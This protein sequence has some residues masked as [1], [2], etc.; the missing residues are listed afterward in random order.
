AL[1][2]HHAHATFFLTGKFCREFPRQARSIA[3]AGMELG[4]HSDTH[5]RF[6]RLSA[7]QIRGQLSRAEDAIARTCG[8]GARPL[9]R[10]PYG[11]S[12]DRTRSVVAAAGYQA[13]GW[14]LDSLDSVGKPKSAAF[15]DA[16]IIHRLRPGYIVLMHVSFPESARSLPA[17][18]DYLDE[19]GIRVV[20][21]SSLLMPPPS[22]QGLQMASLRH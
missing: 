1:E 6:T 3:E 2:S 14:T 18:F 15:V 16:R 12:D 7:E 4:N 19:K 13:V 5:P 21:V 8:R 9:F 17:I 11:D 22:P 20:P 10:Y